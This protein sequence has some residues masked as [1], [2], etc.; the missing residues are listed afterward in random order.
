MCVS[1]E[2]EEEEEEKKEDCVGCRNGRKEE[3]SWEGAKW[4]RGN[5]Q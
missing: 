3:G 4:K 2:E 5:Q 1:E